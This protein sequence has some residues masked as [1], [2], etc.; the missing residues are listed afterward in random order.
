MVK[1]HKLYATY[2]C[3]LEVTGYKMARTL[4]N[5]GFFCNPPGY[6]QVTS[7]YT[8]VTQGLLRLQLPLELS[9]KTLQSTLTLIPR[10]GC[11]RMPLD[12][13]GVCLYL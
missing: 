10:P 13:L 5:Q 7:G 2:L 6:F 9:F 1:Q 3:V 8:G 12:L 4:M 11:P